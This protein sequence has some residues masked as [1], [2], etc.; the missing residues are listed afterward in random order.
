MGIADAS[1]GGPAQWLV[2]A[3][4]VALC[5]AGLA[6]LY[7]TVL[8]PRTGVNLISARLAQALWM[9][10]RRIARGGRRIRAGVLSHAGPVIVIADVLVWVM[11]PLVGFALIVWPALGEEITNPL[12]STSVGFADALY[13]SGATISTLG[14]GD[15]VPTTAGYRL[16]AVAEACLG[17]SI[18]TL[19]VTY[20]LSVYSALQRRN[21]FALALHHRSGGADS[22]AELLARLIPGGDAR[23]AGD[24]LAELSRSLHDLYE[25]HHLYPVLHYFRFKR[26]FY[27]MAHMAGMV[28]DTA[29][30]IRVLLP[31]DRYPLVN[32]AEVDEAW[33]AATMLLA[34]MGRDFLP[35]QF[36][37]DEAQLP[38]ERWTQQLHAAAARLRSAGV[39]VVKLDADVVERYL[40]LR[41]QWAPQAIGFQRYMLQSIAL[42][43]RSD[44]KGGG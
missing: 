3:L 42:H 29:A 13:Y 38:Y 30:L 44:V 33:G 41:R 18:L 7:G 43:E 1:G 8:Y 16:L 28:A 21:I 36:G 14:Y 10:F 39:P 17:F 37:P 22:P 23:S 40:A 2:Q 31:A 32:S 20:L 6:D 26:D 4:G 24:R 27:A 34:D 25:S 11:G 12:G 9:M 5:A 19:S 35:P 15:V